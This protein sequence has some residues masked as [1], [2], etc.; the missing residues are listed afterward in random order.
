MS[1]LQICNMTSSSVNG[2]SSDH[3]TYCNKNCC[4]CHKRA[5][6]QWSLPTNS[7]CRDDEIARQLEEVQMDNVQIVNEQLDEIAR[8]LEEVQMADV[9]IVNEQLQFLIAV[10]MDNVQIV[11][12]QL[13][14]LIAKIQ[15]LETDIMFIKYGLIV[16][17]IVF[18][19]LLVMKM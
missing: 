5:G 18:G 9:Q 13:Q 11:N 14:F 15:K 7:L 10:Q 6:I 2:T 12:E 1:A 8:Q 19:S 4:K 3:L 17:L 16:A